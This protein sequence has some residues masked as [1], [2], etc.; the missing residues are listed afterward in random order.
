MRH[1][2]GTWTVRPFDNAS[3]DQL[4]NRHNPTP[5]HR[6][7]ARTAGVREGHKGCRALHS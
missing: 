7:Q 1:F 4:V 3:L 5:L 6:L 2:D